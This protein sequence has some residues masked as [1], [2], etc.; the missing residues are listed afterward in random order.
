MGHQIEQHDTILSVRETP[1]HKLGTVIP[2]YV[3]PAEAAQLGGL[4]WVAEEAPVEFST[5]SIWERTHA[6]ESHK[7]I[8]RTLPDGT[9][10]TL[11]VVGKNYRAIQPAEMLAIIDLGESR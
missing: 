3:S 7:V 5:G 11:G 10:L 2:D 1:W 6:A 4:D 9:P 8:Y